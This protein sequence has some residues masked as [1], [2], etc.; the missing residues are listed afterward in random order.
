[1]RVRAWADGLHGLR[2]AEDMQPAD[3]RSPATKDMQK[4]CK[5]HAACR[6]AI[7]GCGTPVRACMP[8]TR[9]SHSND[10]N[11]TIAMLHLTSSRLNSSTQMSTSPTAAK[12]LSMALWQPA[13]GCTCGD[14]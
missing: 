10:S 8:C 11:D 5:R 6:P 3:P 4:T 1:M 13:S 14:I 9:T 7:T 12:A 2:V